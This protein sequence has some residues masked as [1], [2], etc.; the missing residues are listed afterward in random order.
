[1]IADLFD[2]DSSCNVTMGPNFRVIQ[3]GQMQW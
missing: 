3:L 1:M 2:G